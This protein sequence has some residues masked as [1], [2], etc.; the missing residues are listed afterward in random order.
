MHDASVLFLLHLF[1]IFDTVDHAPLDLED[2]VS[3]GRT[4]LV[5]FRLPF[6]VHGLEE[7]NPAQDG[8]V[9]VLLDSGLLLQK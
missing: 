3:L 2:E 9:E 5:W 1:A 4:V 7:F 8:T 6:S